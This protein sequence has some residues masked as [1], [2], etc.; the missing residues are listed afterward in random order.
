VFLIHF[1]QM[2]QPDK[3]KKTPVRFYNIGFLLNNSK[4]LFVIQLLTSFILFF[5]TFL[6][7][8]LVSTF[9]FRV[10]LFT[11]FFNVLGSIIILSFTFVS[12]PF[13]II[14]HKKI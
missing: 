2:L 5:I 14:R 8:D 6:T 9:S 1:F 3:T 12:F 13:P 7:K 10:A 11:S 4:P